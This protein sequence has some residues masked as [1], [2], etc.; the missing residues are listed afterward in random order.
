[1]RVEGARATWKKKKGRKE[2]KKKG[3][4]GAARGD[5][6]RERERESSLKRLD[7]EQRVAIK[8]NLFGPMRNSILI[9]GG[10]FAIPIEFRDAKPA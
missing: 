3:E 9:E 5:P 4:K 10:L 6:C 2:E 1:M 7:S 8:R